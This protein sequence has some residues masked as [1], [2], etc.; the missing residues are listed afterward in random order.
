V[1]GR[2]TRALAPA[3]IVL[4]LVAFVAVASTGSARPAGTGETR[5]PAD[6]LLDIFFSFVLVAFIPAAAML[7]WGLMQ[8]KEIA[9][10]F[11][12]G[13]FGRR[14]GLV[15]FLLVAAALGLF[16]YWRLRDPQ[17]QLSEQFE[18]VIVPRGGPATS[19]GEEETPPQY[20]AEF[21]WIPVLVVVLLGALAFAAHY[22]SAR[23]RRRRWGEREAA[24]EA[25]AEVLDDTLDD[26]RAEVDPRKAVIAAYARLER[27][28]AAHGAA[29]KAAET[30]EEYLVRILPGLAVERR[31]IRRLTDLFTRAKF[32]QHEVDTGMKEEAIDAL[33]Q[34]RDELRAAAAAAD[35][36]PPA[37]SPLRAGEGRA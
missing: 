28:L 25:L 4:A 34:V 16:G 18:D 1:G 15:T 36:E 30:P 20:E 32:S 5:R 9:Q 27:T 35:A 17:L 29:R 12:S 22:A 33:A 2:P 6:V 21:A 3:L 13:R 26:H 11:A 19:F 14:S 31:S 8:R 10:G 23:R 7:I 24:A 37:P